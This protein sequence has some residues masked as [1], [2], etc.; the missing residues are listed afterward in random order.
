MIDVEYKRFSGEYRVNCES[1]GSEI[2]KDQLFFELYFNGIHQTIHICD[3]CGYCLQNDV[4][5]VFCKF[6]EY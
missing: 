6:I 2:R 5:D 1:C 4:R 3:D